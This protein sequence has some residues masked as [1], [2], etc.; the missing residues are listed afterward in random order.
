MEI[1]HCAT[2]LRAEEGAHASLRRRP[3]L[4]LPLRSHDKTHA[5]VCIGANAEH[6]KD[7]I[8]RRIAFDG[9]IGFTAKLKTR[10]MRMPP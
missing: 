7:E 9:G 2:V 8:D 1:L 10:D 3:K 5:D 4:R 6:R